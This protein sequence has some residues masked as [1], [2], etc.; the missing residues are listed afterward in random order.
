MP[1]SFCQARG[2]AFRLLSPP[3]WLVNY[4]SC[5]KCQRIYFSVSRVVSY[6]KNNL[7]NLTSELCNLALDFKAVA[8]YHI[9]AMLSEDIALC[10]FT[11]KLA[12]LS[13][14]ETENIFV[15]L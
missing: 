13:G 9:K 14:M 4:F 2:E 8:V 12:K 3:L 6:N 15:K 1:Q 10:L 7:K 5:R 11:M